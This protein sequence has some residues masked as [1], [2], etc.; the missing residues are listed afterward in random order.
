LSR[1]TGEPFEVFLSGASEASGPALVEVLA[2]NL[3]LD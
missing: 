2:T 1:G 3:H